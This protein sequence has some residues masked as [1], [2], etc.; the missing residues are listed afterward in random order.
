M[1]ADDGDSTRLSLLQALLNSEDREANW[2]LF[3]ARYQPLIRR[4]CRRRGLRDA[5]TDDV[6]A[7]VVAKLYARL[8][9]YRP[10]EGGFRPWLRAVVEN[11]VRDHFRAARR[12]PGDA[13]TG[14]SDVQ[15]QLAQV[16][17]PNALDELA[18]T[19]DEV[20][21]ADQQRALSAVRARVEPRSWEAYL[22]RVAHQEPAKDVAAALGMTTAAVHEAVYRI[23]KQVQ[24]EYRALLNTPADP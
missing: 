6:S 19:V 8:G 9:A 22:R 7:A 12:R 13:G 2:G 11:A 17:D 14:D 20:M 15:R 21:D 3:L 18:S 10:E 5:A 23:R 4:W 16:A 24:K 1:G